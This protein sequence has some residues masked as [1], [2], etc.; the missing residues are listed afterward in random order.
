M[1]EK[2][3]SK[4]ERELVIARL[5][6]LSPEICF[7]SGHSSTISRDDLISHIKKNDELGKNFV[8][9][10]LEFLR[11]IKDGNLMKELAAD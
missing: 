5:E 4:K 10:E 3:V 6:V 7:S 1:N 9:I 8:N 2:D 11:A